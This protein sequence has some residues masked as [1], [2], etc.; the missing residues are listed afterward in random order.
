MLTQYECY[1]KICQ[2][3]KLHS[4]G[5]VCLVAFHHWP[6]TAPTPNPS[7]KSDDGSLWH[8]PDVVLLHFFGH[9]VRFQKRLTTYYAPFHPP[10]RI[11]NG[12]VSVVPGATQYEPGVVVGVGVVGILVGVIAIAVAAAVAAAGAVVV[13]TSTSTSSYVV[14]VWPLLLNKN[15]KQNIYTYT[16]YWESKTTIR[17]SELL[18]MQEILP[19]SRSTKP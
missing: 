3:L 4:M 16:S 11:L 6:R 5:Y 13:S 2:H 19:N 10:L 18:F 8:G 7:S 1:V 14:V 17:L 9:S 15:K 12:T